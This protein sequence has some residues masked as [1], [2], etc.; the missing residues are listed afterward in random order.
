MAFIGFIYLI[1]LAQRK[2]R[3]SQ[4]YSFYLLLSIIS[5]YIIL[6]HQVSTLQIFPL[7]VIIFLLEEFVN[8]YVTIE[9]KILALFTVA[10]SAYWVYISTLMSEIVLTKTESINAGEIQQ[11][12]SQIQVGN[13]YL[14][15]WN[16]IDIAITIFL[17]LV[18]IAFLVWAYKCRYPSVIGNTSL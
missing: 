18:G 1:F 14:F 17:V 7:L 15:L 10:F 3:A 16:N 9:P 5:A 4:S 11:L 2:I 8:D 6:V 13:E 12:R